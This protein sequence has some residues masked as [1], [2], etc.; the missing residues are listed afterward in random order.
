MG[1]GKTEV[2]PQRELLTHLKKRID[3]GWHIRQVGIHRVSDGGSPP[4][5]LEPDDFDYW[6]RVQRLVPE[7]TDMEK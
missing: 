4:Q 5:W 2:V 1:E 3:E 7:S 6:V